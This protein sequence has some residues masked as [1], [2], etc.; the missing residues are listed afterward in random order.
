MK[1]DFRNSRRLNKFVCDR[2]RTAGVCKDKTFIGPEWL[3]V[4]INTACNFNCVF[5]WFHSPYVTYQGRAW[6]LELEKF[7][8]AVTDAAEMN[9]RYIYITGFGE[10]TLHPDLPEMISF[11]KAKGLHVVVTTNLSVS[12][13]RVLQGLLSA[14]EL[15]VTFCGADSRQYKR[16]HCPRTK[17]YFGRVL[18]N[19]RA[20]QKMAGPERKDFFLLN[21]IVNKIN[22]QDVGALADLAKTLKIRRIRFSGFSKVEQTRFLSLDAAEVSALQKK[23]ARLSSLPHFDID[24]N[25]MLPYSKLERCFMGWYALLLDVYG[26]VR[27]GCLDPA[28][29][30]AGSIYKER[31]KD[32]WFSQASQKIRLDMKYRLKKKESGHCP[33]FHRNARLEELIAKK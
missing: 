12:S 15:Y 4:E 25:L 2:L 29:P 33:F 27:V 30:A 19:I 11:A 18:S 1:G 16:M 10:P 22:Y 5:C 7:Q 28:A 17:S 13:P 26:E 3:G 21:V 32:I 14:D 9:C 8:E 24:E 6:Q 31:L 20:L 23:I